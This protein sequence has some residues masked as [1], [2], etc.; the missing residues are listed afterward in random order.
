MTSV[1]MYADILSNALANSPTELTVSELVNYGITLRDGID[2]PG[3]YGRSAAEVLVAE[4]AYDRVL[5]RLCE[6]HRI[7]VDPVAFIHPKEA[8]HCLE[9]R[10]ESVGVNIVAE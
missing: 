4:I 5:I 6:L 3:T 1:S 9:T 10:L 2:H 7:A 8:R